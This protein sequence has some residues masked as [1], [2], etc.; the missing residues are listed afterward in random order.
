MDEEIVVL[1]N[2][3]ESGFL[4]MFKV[5]WRNVEVILKEDGVR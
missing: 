4:E 2:F 1:G 5:L 3:N